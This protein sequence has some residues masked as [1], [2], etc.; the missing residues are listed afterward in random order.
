MYISQIFQNVAIPVDKHDLYVNRE[1]YTICEIIQ[2]TIVPL[3][4]VCNF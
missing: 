4:R 1:C 2:L 3:T